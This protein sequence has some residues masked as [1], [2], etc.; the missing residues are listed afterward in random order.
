MSFI[1]PLSFFF[2]FVIV[3]CAFAEGYTADI[4]QQHPIAG[5]V[6]RL[7]KPVFMTLF[8]L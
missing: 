5:S 8:L 7:G 3:P 2:Y 6:P 4:P 1:I